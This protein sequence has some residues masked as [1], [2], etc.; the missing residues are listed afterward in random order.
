MFKKTYNHV[1]RA[2]LAFLLLL[3]DLPLLQSSPCGHS[4]HEQGF[5]REGKENTVDVVVSRIK[6]DVGKNMKKVSRFNE[7]QNSQMRCWWKLKRTVS[8]NWSRALNIAKLIFDVIASASLNAL[9]HCCF[10]FVNHR[11]CFHITCMEEHL[12]Q[13]DIVLHL[14]SSFFNNRNWYLC[15][16]SLITERLIQLLNRRLQAF[17]CTWFNWICLKFPCCLNITGRNEFNDPPNPKSC[18]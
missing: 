1:V 10:V 3:Q 15:N 17:F 2:H 12:D 11:F 18:S 16:L 14:T 5:L 4:E 7:S 8:Q 13:V 6:A 9:N